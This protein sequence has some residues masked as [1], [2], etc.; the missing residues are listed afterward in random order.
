MTQTSDNVRL[1]VIEGDV[2]ALSVQIYETYVAPEESDLDTAA[3]PD[4]SGETLHVA[5]ASATDEPTDSAIASNDTASSR[6]PELHLPALPP[7]GS[8]QPQDRPK[9]TSPVTPAARRSVP[10]S[11][12]L[13]DEETRLL[14]EVLG[15]RFTDAQVQQFL[16]ALQGETTPENLP[17]RSR[18]APLSPRTVNRYR[19]GA[20]LLLMILLGIGSSVVLNRA[21]GKGLVL[22]NA[23]TGATPSATP[24]A[25]PIPVPQLDAT[26]TS[27]NVALD[28]ALKESEGQRNALD[29]ARR[30]YLLSLAD[31]EVKKNGTPVE[32]WLIRRL[33]AQMLDLRRSLGQ[34]GQFSGEAKQIGTARALVGD[35]RAILLALQ[36]EWQSPN[37]APGRHRIAP[38]VLT[39]QMNELAELARV[40]RE[41]SYEQQL[42]DA[43][44]ARQ[45]E[46]DK[47]PEVQL[48]VLP[49]P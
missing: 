19:L 7:L 4:S 39:K 49:S 34:G 48:N 20:L 22:P 1:R 27:R 40:V 9:P 44:Q 14:L 38:A 13:T 32:T 46:Q 45:Q 36:Q 8:F 26:L 2:E 17:A 6:Q 15:D 33:N 18:P 37:A 23:P 12:A 10:S 31:A 28:A 3:L 47:K 35:A 21:Q 25:T 30:D 42:R 16:H 11:T 24:G 5:D 43:E 29:L 41:A